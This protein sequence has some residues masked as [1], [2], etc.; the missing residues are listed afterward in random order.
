MNFHNSIVQRMLRQ[1]LLI[2]V[3]CTCCSRCHTPKLFSQTVTSPDSPKVLTDKQLLE[4]GLAVASELG[5]GT[6]AVY[7][8]RLE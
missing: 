6:A 4:E 1:L 7:D 3:P 2:K 8:Y 5:T